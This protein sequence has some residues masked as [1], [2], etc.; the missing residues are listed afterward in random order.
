MNY[1]L[2]PCMEVNK[3]V[4]FSLQIIEKIIIFFYMDYVNKED[5]DLNS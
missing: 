1:I 3:L 2:L 4:Y 5:N